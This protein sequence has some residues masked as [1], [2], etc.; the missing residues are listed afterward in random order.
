M[1]CS[2]NIIQVIESFFLITNLPLISYKMDGNELYSTG[3]ND[4]LEEIFNRHNIYEKAMKEISNNKDNTTFTIACP[5]NI[6]YIVTSICPENFHRGIFILGPCASIKSKDIKIPYK[7]LEIKPYLI[8]ILRKLWK[9]KKK[10]CK[11]CC[12]NAYSLHIKK[13]IDYMDSRYEENITLDD[14]ADYINLNKSYFS[15]LFKKETGKTFTEFLNEIRIEKSK[16]L[17]LEDKN[18]ILDIA[19]AVG[20]NNQNYYNIIF[21]KITKQTPS[22]FKRLNINGQI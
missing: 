1:A 20:F 4:K 15:S 21:K 12:N 22:E 10:E 8:D 9:E 3:Y 18:S 7:P 6:Y 5:E 11:K 16:E 14:V 13:A 19:L 2:S 17:L